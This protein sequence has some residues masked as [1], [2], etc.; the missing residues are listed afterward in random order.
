MFISLSIRFLGHAPL[1]LSHKAS[2]LIVKMRL[3]IFAFLTSLTYVFAVKSPN[4]GSPVIE[5]LEGAIRPEWTNT[6]QGIRVLP[7]IETT[8]SVIIIMTLCDRF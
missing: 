3:I 8:Q 7:R 4:A 2:G 5:A 1:S 6:P